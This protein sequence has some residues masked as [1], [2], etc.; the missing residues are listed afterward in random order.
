MD[1]VFDFRRD[2][3]KRDW[4][5]IVTRIVL[6]IVI[7][8][9]I[10]FLFV[11]FVSAK[12][13]INGRAYDSFN[14]TLDASWILNPFWLNA[15]DQRY[16]DTAW[17]VANYFNKAQ[18]DA[19]YVQD[20]VDP[21]F[22]SQNGSIW[23]AIN[24][25]LDVG[26]QRYNESALINT[27]LDISDQRYNDTAFI[28]YVNATALHTY[29]NQALYGDLSIFGNLNVVGSVV[30]LTVI[31]QIVNGSILPDVSSLFNLGSP[32]QVWNYIYANNFIGNINYSF[33]QNVPNFLL[34]DDQRYNDTGYINNQL[35]NY[36]PTNDQRYNDTGYCDARLLSY[37]NKSEVDVLFQNSS[38]NLS[39]VYQQIQFVNSS[40]KQPSGKYLSND[41]QF[42][43]VDEAQ[44]NATI[45]NISKI[46]KGSVYLS[47]L[48]NGSNSSLPIEY[49]ITELKVT[50]QYN[51]TLYNFELKDSVGNIIDRDRIQHF[52][53]WDI[54][55]NHAI[56]DS[57]T[58]TLSNV[59]NSETFL[60]EVIYEYNGV[61]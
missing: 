24:S 17:V 40:I 49:E 9:S 20:E 55:K 59:S 42:F 44:L 21:V 25:K 30:N 14:R 61:E 60:I 37:Y 19:R 34:A 46:R 50:P 16:N 39:D 18:S 3:R 38:V 15:S 5:H 31:Q 56:N 58:A 27:K 53:V 47:I 4:S 54:S 26:D 22:S 12:L 28:V 51:S 2:F 35:L 7:F 33:V 13:V 48:G 11:S 29:G 8:S 43:W 23:G 57:V 52:G 32:S 6:W 10:F 1:D 45:R 41:S 36:L